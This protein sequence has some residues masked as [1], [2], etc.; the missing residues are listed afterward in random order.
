MKKDKIK[1][2]KKVVI[3]I[4]KNIRKQNHLHHH[5]ILR[6]KDSLKN[7][8]RGNNQVHLNHLHQNYQKGVPL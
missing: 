7:K 6:K 3:L 4:H 5:P 1:A 8:K 2:K